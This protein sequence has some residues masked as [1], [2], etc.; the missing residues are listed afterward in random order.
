VRLKVKNDPSVP[1]VHQE[2]GFTSPIWYSPG[3]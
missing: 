2:R 3:T 1:L